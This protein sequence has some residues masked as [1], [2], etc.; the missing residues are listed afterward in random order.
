MRNQRNGSQLRKSQKLRVATILRNDSDSKR[1][2]LF[3]R[4]DDDGA[5]RWYDA[6]GN[7]TEVS[8]S[9]VAAACR[10]MQAGGAQ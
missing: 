9:T 10:I 7:D 4:N 6:E 2:S 3:L 5:Y 8:A 1:I